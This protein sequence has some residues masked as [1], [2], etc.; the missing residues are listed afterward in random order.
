[1]RALW[2]RTVRSVVAG[3]L[4]LSVGLSGAVVA[5]EASADA[6]AAEIIRIAGVRAG[7]CVR[8]GVTDGRLTAALGRSGTFVVHGLAATDAAVD[9]ARARVRAQGL[10]GRV[11][12]ARALPAALPHADDTVNLLVSDGLPAGLG[13]REVMRALCPGGVACIRREGVWTRAVKPRPK[14]MGDWTHYRHG[15]DGNRVGDDLLVGPPAR[16]RWLAGPTWS[17]RHALKTLKGMVSSGGRLF[18]VY[19]RAP[20]NVAGPRRLWLVARDG[21]NGVRLWD[22]AVG[23]VHRSGDLQGT[24][25]RFPTEALVAAG[26]RVYAVLEAGGPLTALD[27]ST[28]KTVKV[29]GEV[30]SPGRVLCCGDTLVLTAK[31]W[32]GAVEAGTGKTRWSAARSVRSVVAAAGKVFTHAGR[33][34][35]CLDLA[36]GRQLW[37]ADL[38]KW[39][40]PRGLRLC[41]HQ[42]GR[43]FLGGGLYAKPHA[44]HALS[45]AD[46]TH[47]WSRK[48]V[49]GGADIYAA[50]GLVWLK[51]KPVE[52]F[53]NGVQLG[54]DP[55]SGAVKKRIA[56]PDYYPSKRGHSR[57]YSNAATQRYILLSS[58]GTDFVDLRTGLV[59]DMQ[60]FCGDCGFGLVP[61]NGLL[62]LAP[63]SCTCFRYLGGIRALAAKGE[64]EQAAASVRLEKGPA[65]KEAAGA[66]AGQAALP[67]DWPTLRHDAWRS[68]IT[69]AAVPA[70]AE[71]LWRVELGGRLSAPTVAA[72]SL[73][74]ASVDSHQVVALRAADG[75]RLWAFTAGGRVDSPPTLHKGLCLFGCR[76]GWVYCLRSSD[77]ALVWRF[78]AAPGERRIVVRDQLES[79]WPVRGSVLV[80]DDRVC[81]SSGR[82]PQLDGGVTVFGLEPRSG[83]LVWRRPFPASADVLALGYYGRAVYLGRYQTDPKTG[84]AFRRAGRIHVAPGSGWTDGSYAVRRRWYNGTTN[85]ELMVFKTDATF[86][87][88]Y[89]FRGFER[90]HKDAMALPGKRENS[91]SCVAGRK[92][93][94]P[95]NT[96]LPVRVR[97]MVLAG[98]VLFVAGPPD[99]APPQDYWAAFDDKLGAEL[100]A[101]SSKDG[102]KLGERKL[103]SAPVFDGLV[104]AG[105]RLYL[106]TRSGEL[107]CL[108][109]K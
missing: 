68:G 24:T 5:G 76:D 90:P 101:V 83:K 51:S 107:M 63:N 33:T 42:D 69:A 96:T 18:Y 26:D 45:A 41:F 59:H 11:S 71:P 32:L 35:T 40:N 14:D 47:L 37:A 29:Y 79:P 88:T 70:D 8:L 105:T 50:A 81:F 34:V 80:I 92:K 13:M 21:C 109:R 39:T 65:Y 89:A 20:K 102:S 93:P 67:T 103:R 53:K 2:H 66:P 78:R 77:G 23:S 73:Y 74:V 28:G 72:G 94:A 19:D 9:A 58:R 27:G 54:L 43:L 31:N 22:R 49:W 44:V 84:Q 64:G 15:A 16:L 6:L 91:L 60:A 106:A 99:V 55:A 52:G 87:K 25:W 30:P 46:G 12:V 48:G 98:D 100:W 97:A 108:G 10:Y 61:A 75:K 82:A 86:P 17:R 57:C 3:A 1:M 36:T 7:L 38:G 56:F 95:W 4:V 104:A 62:Y 85:G